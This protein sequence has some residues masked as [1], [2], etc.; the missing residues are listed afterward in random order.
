MPKKRGPKTDVLEALLKRVDG[1]EAKLREKND[2]DASPTIANAPMLGKVDA[3][4]SASQGGE[5][6]EPAP[7][8]IAIEARASPCDTDLTM[9][10]PQTPIH[11][12]DPRQSFG[13][14]NPESNYYAANCLP[15]PPRQI[16]FLTPT[17]PDFMAS[18]ITFSTNPPSGNGFS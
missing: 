16:L 9:L 3:S 12:S 8:R 14:W 18:H 5:G 17:S 4:V 11:R 15:V 13:S 6:G 1:L 2:D 7:K 10:S